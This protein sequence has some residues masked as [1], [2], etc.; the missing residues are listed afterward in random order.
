MMNSSRESERFDIYQGDIE[1]ASGNRESAKNI[2]LFAASEHSNDSDLPPR[3]RQAKQLRK[4]TQA[5][6]PDFFQKERLSFP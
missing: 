6:S 2:W 3:S 4:R 5:D 1:L